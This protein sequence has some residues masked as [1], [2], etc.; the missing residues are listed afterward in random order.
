MKKTIILKNFW[1]KFTFMSLAFV[2][3]IFIGCAKS[4]VA[5]FV[6]N[7]PAIV[8][9]PAKVEF[10]ASS[11]Q[12][13]IEKYIWSFG[14]GIV[15]ETTTN[16]IS[17]IFKTSGEFTVKLTAQGPKGQLSTNSQTVK[18][19]DGNPVA[20]FENTSSASSLFPS[21]E[22]IFDATNS[23]AIYPEAT[24]TNYKWNFGD[25]SNVEESVNFVTRS[26]IFTKAGSYEV[27]LTILDSVGNENVKS[28]VIVIKEPIPTA[29]F[30]M[31]F[32]PTT[33]VA[34]TT[35]SFDASK[36]V[37]AI[38]TSP[39]S[40]YQWNLGL[41][42]SIT[43]TTPIIQQL[44]SNPGSYNIELIV[45]DSEGRS[46]RI[47]KQ[48]VITDGNPN[49]VYSFSQ[50]GNPPNLYAP[51]FINF[52]ASASTP[53]HA[54][55]PIVDYTWDFGDTSPI[56]TMVNNSTSKFY[57]ASNIYRVKLA[58]KDN[59][60]RIG[61]AYKFLFVTDGSPTAK[62][63]YNYPKKVPSITQEIT[64]NANQSFVGIP[65]KKIAQYLFDFGDGQTQT[66]TT[67][68]VKHQYATAGGKIVKLI[69]VDEDGKRGE[70]IQSLYVSDSI[71]VSF[72]TLTPPDSNKV[73][74]DIE[75]NATNSVDS[76]GSVVKYNWD[77]GDG[78]IQITTNPII[79]HHFTTS[80]WKTVK[81]T[82]TDDDNKVSA[83][84][85]DDIALVDANS[86]NLA[87]SNSNKVNALDFS[88]IKLGL[89]TFSGSGCINSNVSAGIDEDEFGKFILFSFNNNKA[90]VGGDLKTISQLFECQILMPIKVDQDSVM[91]IKGYI[92]HAQSSLDL[93]GKSNIEIKYTL[94]NLS[95][96]NSEKVLENLQDEQTQA[97][98]F[99]LKHEIEK[100]NFSKGN[101]PIL[102]LNSVIN[103]QSINIGEKYPKASAEINSVKLYF[104]INKLIN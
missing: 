93:G 102:K 66:S 95:E 24:I 11:S 67:P 56:L 9:N 77:F 27:K 83:V 47:N 90:T 15:E 13:K 81:L 70:I 34:P 94:D 48:L 84:F 36:S 25:N 46:N 32:N 80:G 28:Q 20:Q 44:Y 21:F 99:D 61:T 42:N 17:H 54:D 43:S 39:I 72:F 51:Q 68:I 59:I 78:Q 37:S 29:N 82:V 73:P 92:H 38:S 2:A 45:F 22:V 69:V 8:M 104:D 53:V 64:F 50:D 97:L 18:I 52:N 55:N 79:T 16:K 23:T 63:V 1:S 19:A 26:H 98:A 88:G 65:G 87:S 6:I 5:N 89:M 62:L 31:S 12:N 75:F 100:P 91:A 76:D 58:V 35:V 60:N 101:N 4:P 33:T 30:D 14:D 10:D 86:S 103:V 7:Y 85:S 3:L 74:V 57:T 49:A 71:P 96:I 40:S 41:G